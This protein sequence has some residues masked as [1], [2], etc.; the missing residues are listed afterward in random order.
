MEDM[1][2]YLEALIEE[3]GRS[4]N[5]EI[6]IDGHIGLEWDA[7]VDYIVVAVEY[8]KQIRDMLVMI[9][10]KNGD[11]FHYLTHLAKGML[12]AQGYEVE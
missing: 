12:A 1:R 2:Q 6:E 3:K 7:L 8:H 9:D 10:F 11:V 5:D 4:L